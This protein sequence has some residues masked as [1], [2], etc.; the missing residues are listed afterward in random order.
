MDNE[1]RNKLVIIICVI[2]GWCH[3]KTLS[4]FLPDYL[5]IVSKCFDDGLIETD[6]FPLKCKFS[7][8]VKMPI[9]WYKVFLCDS[10]NI[11]AKYIHID[12]YAS[13]H[14]EED[15]HS[16]LTEQIVN[17]LGP[18]LGEEEKGG[19]LSIFLGYQSVKAKLCPHL[20]PLP[21]ST[22]CKPLTKFSIHVCQWCLLAHVFCV[23]WWLSSVKTWVSSRSWLSEC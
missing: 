19:G 20:H 12:R 16:E 7:F 9:C 17:L 8:L 21:N 2:Y 10:N 13:R 15:N 11:H 23:W 1:W 22:S 4:P 18:N 5:Y 14:G 6:W 3:A